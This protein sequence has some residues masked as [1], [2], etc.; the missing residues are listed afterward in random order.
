MVA[1]LLNEEAGGGEKNRDGGDVAM[2]LEWGPS[3]PCSC[4]ILPCPMST[5][6]DC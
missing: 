4:R 6:I 3:M 2:K 1:R 5:G